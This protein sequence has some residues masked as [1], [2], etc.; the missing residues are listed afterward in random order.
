MH[1]LALNVDVDP[2]HF[3]MIRP[4]GL[5]VEAVSISEWVHPVPDLEEV[6]RRL[7]GE[8]ESVFGWEI[9]PIT[10]DRDRGTP[11]ES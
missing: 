7:L 5:P 6:S 4:C 3:G 10:R 8:L 9:E 11:E 2:A 1:G